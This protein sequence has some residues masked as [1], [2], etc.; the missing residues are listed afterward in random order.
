VWQRLPDGG[1]AE[2][3]AF[4][5]WLQNFWNVEPDERE[6]EVDPGV[7]AAL[8]MHYA[9]DADVLTAIAG[10]PVPWVDSLASVE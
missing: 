3:P 6:K 10:R 1:R 8:A 2:K 9:K 5:F 4:H 7:R